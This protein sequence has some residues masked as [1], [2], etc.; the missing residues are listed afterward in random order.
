MQ[1]IDLT[2]RCWTHVIR[3]WSRPVDPTPPSGNP[4][5]SQGL[6][7]RTLHPCRFIG[8][9]KRVVPWGTVMVGEAVRAWGGAGGVWELRALSTQCCCE[10]KA[11]LKVFL[12]NNAKRQNSTIRREIRKEA[13]KKEQRK[14]EQVNRKPAAEQWGP[15]QPHQERLQT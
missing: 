3:H 8:Y 14:R 1:V 9:N 13:K 7:A 6:G 4:D 10:P 2:L 5:V 12:Q 15:G 11:A